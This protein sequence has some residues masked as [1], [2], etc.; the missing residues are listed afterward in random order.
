MPSSFDLLVVETFEEY[1]AGSLYS[2]FAE[3]GEKILSV[4]LQHFSSFEIDCDEERVKLFRVLDA[5]RKRTGRVSINAA[6]QRQSTALRP[7]QTLPQAA[8]S[9]APSTPTTPS[10]CQIA[11]ELHLL[12]GA[13]DMSSHEKENV[14]FLDPNAM[15]GSSGYSV[16]PPTSRRSTFCYSARGTTVLNNNPEKD[17]SASVNSLS[18]TTSIAALTASSTATAANTGR[19]KSRITV[20]I[21]KRPLNSR[22]HEESCQDVISTDNA[23]ALILAEPKQKVDLTRYISNHRFHFDEVFGEESTNQEVYLRTA[24]P[25]IDTVFDGGL[26]TC[27]AYGQT[28][29]GKTHTMMGKQGEPG[30]Y[31]LAANDMF[32]RLTNDMT[33]VVSFYEIYSGKLFD[34]LNDRAALRCLEDAKQNVNICGLVEQPIGSVHDVLRV[35]G[36]GNSIRSSGAT[37]ANDSSS[38]SH[39]ILELK[40]RY[41]RNNKQLGKFTFID[42]AG[43][44]RGADTMDCHRQTRMEGSQINKSLLSLKE[45]I[46][47]LD[48]NHRHVPF[49]GSK[50]TEVL[51]DSFTGNCRTVMIGAV[52][53]SSGNCD[54]TLN[55]LRY[56]DRVKELKKDKGE[57]TKADEIMMGPNPTEHVEHVGNGKPRLAPPSIML[58]GSSRQ[59]DPTLAG[60]RSAV[61]TTRSG[62]PTPAATTPTAATTYTRKSSNLGSLPSSTGASAAP[63]S[64]RATPTSMATPRQTST[65]STAVPRRSI[66]GPSSR[67]SFFSDPTNDLLA[68]STGSNWESL[69]GSDNAS[70][71]VPTPLGMNTSNNNVGVQGGAAE[72][73]YHNTPSL[74]DMCAIDVYDDDEEAQQDDLTAMSPTN[75]LRERQQE[76]LTAIGDMQAQTYSMHEETIEEE[77]AS[78]KEE[79]RWAGVVG[80]G[81]GDPDQYVEN[82]TKILEK[83]IMRSNH[84]LGQLK[85]LRELYE[86]ESNVTN[87]LQGVGG[88][89]SSRRL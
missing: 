63:A 67:P 15:N 16:P 61:L 29:S 35:I 79:F 8:A 32:S 89:P 73:S 70:D 27:F 65:V 48:Q 87:Q 82:V 24:R 60:R 21:R 85:R 11:G 86:E 13:H 4:E 7:S 78:M 49:R 40:V 41:T 64:R 1:G 37:G 69:T 46:R 17:L 47:S 25:L 44:E 50:L 66:G 23:S 71:A 19:R 3:L 80:K 33:L 53:P 6:Q 10:S 9:A 68:E 88:R 76:L 12:S 18:A 74:D 42:L 5:L 83:R 45:C 59:Q 20:A 55:T 58:P 2:K 31:A 56:A 28:G 72:S 81:N 43:S 39:A 26:A 52:S 62:P 34:L 14:L 38:R 54:H 36:H 30:L 57:R 22:E 84:I 75:S 77:V 51:R